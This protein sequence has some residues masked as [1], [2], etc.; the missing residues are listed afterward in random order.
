VVVFGQLAAEDAR[1]MLGHITLRERR[2][3]AV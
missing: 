3:T 1:I 2:D